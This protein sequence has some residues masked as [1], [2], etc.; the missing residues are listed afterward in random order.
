MGGGG[1]SG[2]ENWR[3]G[4]MRGMVRNVSTRSVGVTRRGQRDAHEDEDGVEDI[5][6]LRDPLAP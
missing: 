4:G 5:S 6:A 3:G 1:G 2:K